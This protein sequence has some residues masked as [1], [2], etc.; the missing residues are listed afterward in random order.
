VWQVLFLFRF[1]QVKTPHFPMLGL[2]A[3]PIEDG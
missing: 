3:Q 2:T 1:N